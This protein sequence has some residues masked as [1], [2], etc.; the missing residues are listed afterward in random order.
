MKIEFS[1]WIIQGFCVL[2]L[3]VII[4]IPCSAGSI[5]VPHTFQTSN[6]SMWGSGPAFTFNFAN[7]YGVTWN[8]SGSAGDIGCGWFGDCYGVEF[9]AYSSGRIGVD[10]GFQLNSGSVNASVPTQINLSMPDEVNPYLGPFVANALAGYGAGL[11]TTASPGVSA[12]ADLVFE[13][14]AGA[15]GEL[16]FVGC[17]SFG[18]NIVN[19]NAHPELLAF[20]RNNDGELRVLGN[21]FGIPASGDLGG[22]VDYTVYL[23]NIST[24]GGGVPPILSSGTSSFI[25]LSAN[26]V[27]IA[28]NALGLPPLSGSVGPINYNLLSA[29]VGLDIGLYQDFSLMPNVHIHLDVAETGQTVSF[30]AG[31]PSPGINV[32]F[33]ATLLHVTPTFFMNGLFFNDTGFSLE[34]NVFASGGYFGVSGLGSVG[35]LFNQTYDIGNFPISAYDTSFTLGGFDSFTGPTFEIKV[36][37]EPGSLVLLGSGL[38]AIVAAALRKRKNRRGSSEVL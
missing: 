25:D 32:P 16:C 30:D 29:G 4:A 33:D 35:P 20:N 21:N 26:V 36:V 24:S 23:P 31:S 22:Y 9:T 12:Y 1:K 13:I 8:K 19:I 11:L 5:S 3:T 7:F 6:Q 15:R 37:P 14:L 27:N 18:G 17:G 10:L 28:A 34:P 38:A 2:S